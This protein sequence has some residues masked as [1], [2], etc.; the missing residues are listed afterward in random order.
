MNWVEW[1]L[2]NGTGIFRSIRLE[3][4]ERNTSEDFYLF[5][6]RSGGMS[7]S[8]EFPTGIFGFC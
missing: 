7:C 4:E 8:I 2:T 1:E 3:R 6:K 5:R